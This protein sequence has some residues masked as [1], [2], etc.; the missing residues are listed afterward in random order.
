MC[1]AVFMFQREIKRARKRKEV[2]NETRLRA[3]S[4]PE[5]MCKLRQ[6]FVDQAK[7]YFGVPYARKY[8]TPDGK[9]TGLT[10]K[11]E[12]GQDLKQYHITL[13][14]FILEFHLI[15]SSCIMS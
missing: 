11:G 2:P 4:D 13:V 10:L 5:R 3:L 8:W 7:K 12:A 15:I 9:C 1:L 6:M 14:N